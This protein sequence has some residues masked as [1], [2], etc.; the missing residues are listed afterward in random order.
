MERF[1]IGCAAA[2]ERIYIQRPFCVRLRPFVTGLFSV[3]RVTRVTLRY[4]FDG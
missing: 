3:L 1:C 2:C 4:W